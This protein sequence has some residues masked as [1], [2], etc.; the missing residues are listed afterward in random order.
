MQKASCASLPFVGLGRH[1]GSA[2][3]RRPTCVAMVPFR[4]P[5]QST[6]K[7]RRVCTVKRDASTYVEE[8][9]EVG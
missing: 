4:Y 3:M 8:M 9:G 7:R 5:L 6:G 2:L 1:R